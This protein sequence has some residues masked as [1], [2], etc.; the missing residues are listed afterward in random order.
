MGRMSLAFS[1]MKTS[2]GSGLGQTHTHAHLY[3]EEVL[4]QFSMGQ[5][6]GPLVVMAGVSKAR[7]NGDMA[8][9]RYATLVP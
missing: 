8:I 1:S 9:D 7:E 4:S 6:I 2:Y 3:Q 5:Q